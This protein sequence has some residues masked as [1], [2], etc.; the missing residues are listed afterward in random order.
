MELSRKRIGGREYRCSR[1][2]TRYISYD[3]ISDFQPLGLFFLAE[4]YIGY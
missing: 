1:I 4:G 3:D 2:E